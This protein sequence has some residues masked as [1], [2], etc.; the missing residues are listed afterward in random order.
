[1]P[2]DTEVYCMLGLRI[3][4]I[5]FIVIT[6][7]LAAQFQIDGVENGCLGAFLDYVCQT[8]VPTDLELSYLDHLKGGRECL[9]RFTVQLKLGTEH[10]N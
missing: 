2:S 7:D 3:R 6:F 5:V 1:M 10:R 4:L 8:M 9:I